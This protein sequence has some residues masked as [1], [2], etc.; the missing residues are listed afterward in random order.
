MSRPIFILALLTSM[1]LVANGQ[2]KL[3]WMEARKLTVNDFKGTPPDPSEG[4]SLIA[5]FG[6][7]TN[8]KPGEIEHLKTFNRQVSNLFFPDNSWINWT[9]P[10]RLRYVITLF[11]LNEW[12]A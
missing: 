6:F 7:E 2:D 5:N 4:R 3:E 10:S 11:D 8:L 1:T 12:M 9:D